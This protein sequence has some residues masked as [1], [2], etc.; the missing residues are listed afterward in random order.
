MSSMRRPPRWSLLLLC[1][2][3]GAEAR[4]AEPE[5]TKLSISVRGGAC[6]ALL[7]RPPDA[8]A[9]LVFAHGQIMDIHHSFMA[10]MSAALARHGIAT[11]RF[12]FPYAEAKREGLDGRAVLTDA[13]MAAAR[14]GEKRRGSLPLLLGGKSIGGMMAAEVVNSA[15]LPDVRGLVLFSYPLHAPGRP[16]AVNANALRGLK[17]PTLV[18]QGTRDALADLTLLTPLVAGLGPQVKLVTVPDADHGFALS[19]G[20]ARTQE[21][22]YEELASDVANFVATLA[23]KSGG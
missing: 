12:N 16:S 11:L 13:V 4:A 3:L 8:R 1:C 17:L 7:L 2:A 9:L 6:S 23:P 19:A 14:E 21:Q 15:A 10:S 5:L 18:L 22:V 20:S